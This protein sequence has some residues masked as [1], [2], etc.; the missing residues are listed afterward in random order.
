M[1]RRKVYHVTPRADGRWD[2]E[3]AGSAKPSNTFDRKADAVDRAKELA[4]KQPLGQVKIQSEKGRIQTEYTY[5]KD[6]RRYKG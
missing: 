4:K 6:P 2:V 5:G 1:P 3:A